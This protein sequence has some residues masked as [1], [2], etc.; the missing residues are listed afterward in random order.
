MLRIL[1]SPAPVL[2]HAI[3]L[4]TLAWGQQATLGLG[5][6]QILKSGRGIARTCGQSD[7][8]TG[9]ELRLAAPMV[10]RW[11]KPKTIGTCRMQPSSSASISLLVPVLAN[12]GS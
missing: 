6:T 10:S 8:G 2:L 1:L 11:T 12:P 4:P 5:L 9:L 7:Y 3:L